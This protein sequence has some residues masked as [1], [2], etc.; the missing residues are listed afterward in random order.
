MVPSNDAGLQF[1][2][3][4]Y[5]CSLAQEYCR[6]PASDHDEKRDGTKVLLVHVPP[7]G[8]PQTVAEMTF[9]LEEIVKILCWGNVFGI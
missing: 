2:E 1:C 3:L 8:K 9:V 5:Y 6:G 7:I 4:V